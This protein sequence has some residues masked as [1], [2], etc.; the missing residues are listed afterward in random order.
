MHVGQVSTVLGVALPEERA[1]QGWTEGLAIWCAVIIVSFVGEAPCIAR[2]SL[3][4]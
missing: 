2:A 3:C 1:Q 4:G